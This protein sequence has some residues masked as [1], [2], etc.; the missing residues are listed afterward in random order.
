MNNENTE[1]LFS[2]FDYL[3]RDRHKTQKESLMCWG[4]DCGDG[5]FPLVH[6]IAR[7][8]TDYVRE[9]PEADC[10]AFQVKEKFGGLRFYIRGGDDALCRLITEM[11]HKSFEVCEICSGSGSLRESPG[12]AVKTLCDAH[13]AQWLAER[14]SEAPSLF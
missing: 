4:F 2:E 3:F 10:T 1:K 8:I 14:Q 5:W 6:D 13:A 12:G 9:H 7:M 11:A